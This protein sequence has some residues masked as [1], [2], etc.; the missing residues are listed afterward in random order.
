M[1]SQNDCDVIIIGGGMVGSSLAAALGGAGLRV[2]LVDRAD[3]AA[4]ADPG[5]DGRS[6]AIAFGSQQA[7]DAVGLWSGMAAA[8]EPILDIRV[9]D[10]ESLMFL[11]YDHRDVGGE[12]LG[13]I[14][15]NRAI[16]EAL[17]ARI[18]ELAHVDH[19]APDAIAE[20]D[21]ARRGATVTLASG[22]RLTAPLL[23]GADGRNSALRREAGIRVTE[24]RYPQ[25]G[26]VCTVTHDRPHR[27][28]AHERFLPAGPLAFLPM[29]DDAQGR[30][31][32]SIVWTEREEVAPA[33]LALPDA[34][35]A[36]EL[37][38]RFGPSLGDI[39]LLGGRWAYPL[40]LLHAERY[41][42]VRL[43][44]VGDAAHA[45]HPIAGQGLNLGL[46]DVAALAEALVDAH[47]LG[48]DLGAPDVLAGYQRR[49]RFD[50]FVLMAATDGLNRLFSNDLAPV[51]LVRDMGLALVDRLPPVKRLFMRHAMGVVGELPRLLRGE[52]L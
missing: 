27:G 13:Y 44:L 37:A 23:I 20:V 4:Q 33:M 14:V 45:I 36:A 31:R 35:F 10:G 1:T 24:W 51:R 11:H 32:S 17:F 18:S 8:A 41:V 12:P 49:R 15:E 38:R 19:L 29:T 22:E 25:T 21:R 42:D 46:R 50:N 34:A 9:S 5:H 3:P 28:I 2:A 43:A 26:I 40:A 6:S 39:R 7:L 52:P 47:R 30:H 48:L 16:R